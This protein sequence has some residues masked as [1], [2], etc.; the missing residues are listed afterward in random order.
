MA[1]HLGPFQTFSFAA[2]R[3]EVYKVF[4]NIMAHLEALE[5]NN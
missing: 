3:N 4:D 5:K 2:W 1:D